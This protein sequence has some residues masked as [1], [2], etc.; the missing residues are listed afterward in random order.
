MQAAS[1]AQGLEQLGG[2]VGGG[3]I[4][5]VVG[6]PGVGWQRRALLLDLSMLQHVCQPLP[7][8]LLGSQDQCCCF[9]VVIC[10]GKE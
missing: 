3:K 10:A 1:Q 6:H 8:P 7:G 4:L 9:D 2:V 5:A